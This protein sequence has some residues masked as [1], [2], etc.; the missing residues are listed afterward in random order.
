MRPHDGSSKFRRGI[1]RPVEKSILYAASGGNWAAMLDGRDAR[2]MHS[3]EP[4]VAQHYTHGSLENMIS[5]ALDR[6]LA[7]VRTM[8][9]HIT[10]TGGPRAE[11][12]SAAEHMAI[13]L[14]MQLSEDE[15]RHH[16]AV[17][18][19]WLREEVSPPISTYKDVYVS[20]P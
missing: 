9:E 5:L 1:V 17:V 6:L 11:D 13:A 12:L 19:T 18:D 20:D 10:A 3:V 8:A 16:E 14:F 7:E 2:N 4:A 15:R